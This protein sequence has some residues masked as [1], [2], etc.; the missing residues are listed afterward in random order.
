M[1]VKIKK[2]APQV[3]NFSSFNK[4]SP[5]AVKIPISKKTGRVLKVKIK[6][7]DL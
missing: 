3:K 4:V 7:V 6:K 1:F 5:V 2:I